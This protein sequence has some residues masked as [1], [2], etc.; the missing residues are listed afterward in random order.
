[1]T[2]KP[3]TLATRLRQFASV[4]TPGPWKMVKRE[5]GRARR[6]TDVVCE[7][8]EQ[9]T[10][11]EMPDN[12]LGVDEFTARYI[13]ASDPQTMLSLLDEIERLAAT[14]ARQAAEIMEDIDRINDLVATVARLTVDVEKE[15]AGKCHWISLAGAQS[16]RADNA[17]ARA[18]AAETRIR[19]AWEAGFKLAVSYGD[20]WIHF[21]GEQKER[22]WETWRAAHSEEDQ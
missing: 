8:D 18:T 15:R 10:I 12:D 9:A 7:A 3:E 2:E 20:N 16:N 13:A 11:C 22:Q 19:E 6:Y 5:H 14:V 4:C 21:D 17:E 1:M